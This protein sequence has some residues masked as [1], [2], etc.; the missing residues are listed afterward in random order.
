MAVAA[1]AREVTDVR[2]R[3]AEERE[4][5]GEAV[6]ELEQTVAKAVGASAKIGGKVLIVAAGAFVLGFALAV[7]NTLWETTLQVR[8][9]P[10]ALSRVSAYDWLAST[11][12][13]PMGMAFA[14]PCAAVFGARPTLLVA[15]FIVIAV[16]AV[17]LSFPSIRNF[18][19]GASYARAAALSHL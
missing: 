19:N 8:V 6:D 15:A 12:F 10:S 14:G 4:Q 11:A 7:G 13:N 9:P 2:R 5:L 18:R 16:E 1:E 3:I 17:A